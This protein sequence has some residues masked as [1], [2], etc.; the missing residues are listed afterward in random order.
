MVMA[1]AS[2]AAAAAAL[3]CFS[4][5]PLA[6]AERADMKELLVND[7]LR[8]RDR[9]HPERSVVVVGTHLSPLPWRRFPVGLTYQKYSSVM[10]LSPAVYTT[11][12]HGSGFVC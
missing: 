12:A 3:Q 5:L 6:L 4:A 10:W 11:G 7:H 9:K 1:C 8:L 2:A